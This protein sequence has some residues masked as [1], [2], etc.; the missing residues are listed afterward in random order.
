MTPCPNPAA[1]EAVIWEAGLCG[2][3]FMVTKDMPLQ[4][5]I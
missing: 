4:G 1:R 2:A 5:V 3:V